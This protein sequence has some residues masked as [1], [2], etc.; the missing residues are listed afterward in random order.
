MWFSRAGVTI[1][2]MENTDITL[3]CFPQ[4]ESMDYEDALRAAGFDLIITRQ[5]DETARQAFLRAL[6]EGRD[7]MITVDERDGFTPADVQTLADALHKQPGALHAGARVNHTKKSLAANIFG[8]LSGIDAN[9]VETSLYGM[10]V[11]LADKIAAMKGKDE[12]FMLN[13]PLEARIN[14]YT[15]CEVQTAAVCDTQPQMALLTRSFKLYYVFIKFSIAAFIAYLVD[16]G[17]FYLFAN[18]FAFMANEYKVLFATVLSRV[19]C[20][21]ATYLLNKG[22]VFKSH[23]KGSG[24]VV[25]FVIL[26]AGQLV[27][28]WL[29]VAGIGSLLGGG[30]LVETGVKIVVDLLIFIASFSIQR[31]WVFKKTE[32][33]LR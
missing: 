4:G 1:L 30:N 12:A 18:V 14:D 6:G 20:S 10:N 15:V 24:V 22:A 9:D 17:T 3:V 32:G 26:A 16:I 2:P 31:D 28:S 21:I 11:E 25:R 13:I 5:K 19:L 33:I 8:F 29:L 27:L 23:V 7:F